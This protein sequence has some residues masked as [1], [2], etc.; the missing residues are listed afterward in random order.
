MRRNRASTECTRQAPVR[1]RLSG[2][3][4]SPQDCE[5]RAL[6][7]GTSAPFFFSRILRTVD[8]TNRAESNTKHYIVSCVFFVVGA[9]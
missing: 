1:V 8:V 6:M 9:K 4:H 7:G 2:A 3:P 5:K